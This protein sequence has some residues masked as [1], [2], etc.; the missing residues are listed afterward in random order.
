MEMTKDNIIEVSLGKSQ[1]SMAEGELQATRCVKR[2]R[3]EVAAAVSSVD[4]TN[5]QQLSKQHVGENSTN[6][7]TKRSSKFRGVSR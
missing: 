7:T 4:D 5:H 3:R 6:N 2:R 1:M